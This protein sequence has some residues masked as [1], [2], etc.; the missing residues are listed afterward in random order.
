MFI[1]VHISAL[2]SG[3]LRRRGYL[4]DEGVLVDESEDDLDELS[5][6]Q[7]AAVQ[8]LIPFGPRSGQQALLFGDPPETVA[9][10]PEKKLCADHDGYSLH[11][12]IRIG[13]GN[14]TRLER[15]QPDY[16]NFRTRTVAFDRDDHACRSS[17]VRR[18]RGCAAYLRRQRGLHRT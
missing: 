8:G 6:H 5:T 10:R 3:H 11:A 9:P 7:A 16:V 1:A 17:V 15:L 2:I 14:T 13:A 4:D 18:D 12:A